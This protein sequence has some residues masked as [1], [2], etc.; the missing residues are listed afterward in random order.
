MKHASGGVGAGPSEALS[1]NLLVGLTKTLSFRQDLL[2][3]SGIAE[4]VGKA[5]RG[6]EKGESNNSLF[7]VLHMQINAPLKVLQDIHS[8]LHRS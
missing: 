3:L 2:P 7:F 1:R 4:A 8:A 5:K 6:R